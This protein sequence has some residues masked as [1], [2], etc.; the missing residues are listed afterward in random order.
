MIPGFNHNIKYKGK[1]Y[2]VQTEDS[3]EK[4]PYVVSHIFLGGNIL[5]TK[6]TS[7]RDILSNENRNAIVEEMM[8]E[9]HKSMIKE[10]I[11]GAWENK[12]EKASATALDADQAANSEKSLDQIILD[13]L[14]KDDS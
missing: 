6:R 11:A 8:K 7:Y 14:S 5:A 3:G 13:Y 12:M 1:I 10:L 4:N 2:H 9:Q